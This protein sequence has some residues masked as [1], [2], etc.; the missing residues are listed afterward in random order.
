MYVIN[1]YSPDLILQCQSRRQQHTVV[2]LC[3][4]ACCETRW[5]V[6]IQATRPRPHTAMRDEQCQFVV[7]SGDAKTSRALGD[8]EIRLQD[9]GDVHSSGVCHQQQ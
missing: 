2:T 3:A 5:I 8:K 6:N 9:A 7:V 4:E 1:N